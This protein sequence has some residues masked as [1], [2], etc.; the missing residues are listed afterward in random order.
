MQKMYPHFVGAS[1]AR[2]RAGSARPYRG[3]YEFAGNFTKTH[4]LRHPHIRP[5]GEGLSVRIRRG[6]AWFWDGAAAVGCG[7]PTLP[8]LRKNPSGIATSLRSSQST[9]INAPS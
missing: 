5:R 1:S 9:R 6:V 3:W 2:P 4:C 7:Q 8:K